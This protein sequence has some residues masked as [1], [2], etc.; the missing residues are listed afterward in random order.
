MEVR[1]TEIPGVVVIQPRVF[2]DKRGLFK[3]TYQSR[4]YHE[5]G[6][7]AD[8]VQDNL[9]RSC[10]GALRGLHFQIEHPQGKLLQVFWGEVFDV[11]VDLRRDSPSFGKWFGLTLSESNH[12]QLYVPPGIAHGFYVVSETADVFYKC[13]DFY[14]PEYERTLVWNDPDVG[15]EWPLVGEPVLSEKDQRGLPLSKIECYERSPE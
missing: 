4:R 14:Y 8:F 1:K 11:A 12:T 2:G 7:P 15:I 5:A 10:R 6:L 3:E 9:S 13:T